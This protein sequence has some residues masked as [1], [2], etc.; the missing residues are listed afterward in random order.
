MIAVP[1]AQIRRIIYAGS[2]PEA[3][4]PLRALH[5]AGYEI[6]LVLSQPQRRRGR[7]GGLQPTPVA[8]AAAAMG[9]AVSDDLDDLADDPARVSADLGVV[10]AYGRIIPRRLLERLA[11]VNLHF[12]LLPRWRG[13]APVERAI[14]AGDRS[15]GVSLMQLTE[16]LDT[17]PVH[18]QVTVTIG[19]DESARRLRN[20]LAGIGAE[21]LLDVLARGLSE[22]L[23]QVGAAGYAHRLSPDELQ[24]DW[25][26]S[27]EEIAR[28]VRVGGAWTTF[29]G[30]RLKVHAAQVGHAARVGSETTQPPGPCGVISGVAVVTGCGAIQLSRVQPEGRAV[31]AAA[32]WVNGVRL[33]PDERFDDSQRRAG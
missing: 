24:I 32:D 19:V 28:L 21:L 6:P 33:Q 4:V 8:E 20:R 16:G 22:P 3:V 27:A 14:L 31:M 26:V 25:S 7:G 18:A 29:R 10:V 12:S 15:T 23:P 1:P 9:L 11:M 30:R 17:G 13:A 2:P 5:E